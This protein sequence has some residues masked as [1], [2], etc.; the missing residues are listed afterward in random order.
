VKFAS[1]L[2]QDNRIFLGKKMKVELRLFGD[3]RKYLPENNNGFSSMIVLKI[4][5]TVG[6]LLKQMNIPPEIPKII[7][8]NSLHAELYQELKD[9]DT[10]SVFPPVAGG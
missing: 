3:L 2:D 10:V 1:F 6:D 9:G 7:L 8:V 4:G 5:K